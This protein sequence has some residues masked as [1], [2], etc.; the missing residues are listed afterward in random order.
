[1]E[2]QQIKKVVVT[3]GAGFIGTHV[4]RELRSHNIPVVIFDSF[5]SGKR[6]QIPEEVRIIEGDVRNY[7][8]LMRAFSGATHVVHLAA[9][10]SVPESVEDPLLTH[11]VNVNGMSNVLEAARESGVSRVVYASSAAVYGDEPSLPKHEHSPL[12]PQSPYALSKIQNEYLAKFYGDIHNMDVVGLRFFNVYGPGQTGDHKYASVIP[13]W[14]EAI[15]AGKTLEVFGNG[16]QTRDF[17]HV[18]DIAR[19]IYKGLIAPITGA[20]VYNIASGVQITLRELKDILAKEMGITID[21]TEKPERAGDILHSYAN[22]DK[23]KQELDFTAETS[24]AEG[25]KKLVS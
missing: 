2:S 1:M 25:V 3:G 19:A 24:F 20:P 23:A 4:V 17:V 11:E 22:V 15:R 10:V 12:A 9:V 6:E 8:A 5:V 21:W 16:S 13:R 18:E 14:I 7:G